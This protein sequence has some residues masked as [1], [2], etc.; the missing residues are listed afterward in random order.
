MEPVKGAGGGGSAVL[1]LFRGVVT[2][3][4]TK[5]ELPALVGVAVC[6]GAHPGGLPAWP[7]QGLQQ[8]P[9]HLCVSVCFR[10]VSSVRVE[11]ID[12]SNIVHVPHFSSF[13]FAVKFSSVMLVV[14]CSTFQEPNLC[15]SCSRS[16]RAAEN[17][18]PWLLL[19]KCKTEAG[20]G[21]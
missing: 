6:V 2:E 16:L 3:K 4:W 20:H 9:L 12:I 15:R 17:A 10:C 21:L 11:N 7:G 13:C 5:G 14:M 19:L 1:L 8:P 18:A